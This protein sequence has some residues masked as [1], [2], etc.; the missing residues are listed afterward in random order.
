MAIYQLTYGPDG[1]ETVGEPIVSQPVWGL[2]AGAG[3]CHGCEEQCVEDERHYY[4]L[5]QAG[6]VALCLECGPEENYA[7]HTAA[8]LDAERSYL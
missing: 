8:R 7:E 6:T 1:W 2:N 4:A 3:I 5:P